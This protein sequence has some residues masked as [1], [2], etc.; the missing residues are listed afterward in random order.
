MLEPL[1]PEIRRELSD[2]RVAALRRSAE[3]RP[4]GPLRRAVG[5]ALVRLGLRLGYDGNVPPFVSQPSFREEA[6]AGV[7]SWSVGP[8]ASLETSVTRT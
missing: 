7:S 4:A 8:S 5:S 6:P 1:T 3:R 2:A